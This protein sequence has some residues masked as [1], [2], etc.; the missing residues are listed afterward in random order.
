MTIELSDLRSDWLDCCDRPGRAHVVRSI[1]LL[2]CRAIVGGIFVVQGYTKV[3]GGP[4]K[5]VSPSVARYLGSGFAQSMER[6]GLPSTVAGFQGLG[7]LSPELLAPFVS[8]LELGGGTLTILGL[9]TRPVALLLAGD[10]A[11]AIQKAHWRNGLFGPSG[12][13][14]PLALLAACLGLVGAGAG[15]FSIDQLLSR[16]IAPRWAARP[17]SRDLAPAILSPL[18]F[19]AVV[20]R[21][22]RRGLRI[23]RTGAEPV[24]S[25]AA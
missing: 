19:A 13:N 10:L 9:L 17:S 16:L 15:A 14:F 2:G 24:A 4:G 22:A 12:F 11:V 7:I 20:A 23:E 5:T 1:A 21:L 3:F 8:F 6:G 25:R 18:A